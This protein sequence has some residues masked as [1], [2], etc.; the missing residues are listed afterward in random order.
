MTIRIARKVFVNNE[1]IVEML[2]SCLLMSLTV[3]I[4]R[5]L[6][7]EYNI[8]FV[9]MMRNFLS[10]LMFLP[11]ML[12]TNQTAL[13]NKSLK[14]H[15]FRGG[16][17]AMSMMMWYYAVSLLPLSEA[18]SLT[19]IVPILTTLAATFIF[20]EKAS[21]KIYI[22]CLIGFLG[23]LIILRP[24]F[25]EFKIAHLFVLGAIILWTISN[26]LVK[27]MT[28]TEKPLAIVAYMS[29]FMLLVSIPFAASHLQPIDLRGFCWFI[30]LVIFSNLAHFTMARAFS[31]SPISVLQPFDFSRL[32]FTSLIAYFAF[33]EKLDGFVFL[34]A[35]IIFLAIIYSLPT[36]RRT[37]IKSGFL[38]P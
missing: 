29:F 8:F 33:N 26:L 25:R 15:F 18:V 9:I 37:K 13:H 1:A 36:K 20:R 28:K 2:L 34:G 5:I 17:G 16:N 12:F 11:Q 21:F 7:K 23:V 10:C 6:S 22:S 4:V 32:I 30:L 27:E 14:L 19:F 38:E 3:S 24:G 35:S 31:K